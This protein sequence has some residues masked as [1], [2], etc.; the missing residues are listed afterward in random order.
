[1]IKR[2]TVIKRIIKDSWRPAAI[3]IGTVSAFAGLSYLSERMLG[4]NA[5]TVYWSFVLVWFLGAGVKWLYE[6]KRDQIAFEQKEMMRD[7]E[8]KHL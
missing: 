1:M 2:S 4:W 5:N 7:I 6:A 3:M 8:R